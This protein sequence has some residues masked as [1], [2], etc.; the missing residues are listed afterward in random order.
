M[1]DKKSPNGKKD[2]KLL[3]TD[4]RIYCGYGRSFW[5]DDRL[6]RTRGGLIQSIIKGRSFPGVKHFIF[7]VKSKDGK[8]ARFL[9]RAELGL[10]IIK[11]L[12]Q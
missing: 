7:P 10:T 12:K 2:Q 1:I 3:L 9:Y 11:N 4:G 8:R 6:I 5:D